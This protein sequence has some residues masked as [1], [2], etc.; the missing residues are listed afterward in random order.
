MQEWRWKDG[1]PDERAAMIRMHW[2]KFDNEI[3]CRLF[4]L[5]PTGLAKIACGDVWRPE[6]ETAQPTPDVME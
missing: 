3:V 5:S 4:R 2:R 6:Y 1:T